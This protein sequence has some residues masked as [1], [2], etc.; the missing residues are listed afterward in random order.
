L[1][2][3]PASGA[4]Q[5]ADMGIWTTVAIVVWVRSHHIRDFLRQLR[6]Y[7]RAGR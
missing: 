4:K 7:H 6:G 5:E 1:V 3:I 2:Q